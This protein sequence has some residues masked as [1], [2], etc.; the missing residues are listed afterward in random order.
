M[1][2][3]HIMSSDR[4]KSLA[5]FS[6]IA[7]AALTLI[8][9][10]TIAI[11]IQLAAQNTRYTLIDIGTFGGPQSYINSP[12]NGFPALNTAGTVVGSAATSFPAPL[13]LQSL[14]LWR[15]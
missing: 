2:K 14:W 1:K 9:L 13:N 11:P 4:M 12:V 10:A 8:L 7:A 3:E 6:A 15:S 5:S